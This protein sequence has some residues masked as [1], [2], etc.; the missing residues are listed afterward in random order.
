[1]KLEIVPKAPKFR[2]YMHLNYG[3]KGA[4]MVYRDDE[5]GIQCDIFTPKKRGVWQAEQRIYSID[6][7][8]REFTTLPELMRA[9]DAKLAQASHGETAEKRLNTEKAGE[10][11]SDGTT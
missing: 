5:M 8:K 2:M 3:P 4:Q 11:S 10:E 6:G 7:D 1:M 9:L